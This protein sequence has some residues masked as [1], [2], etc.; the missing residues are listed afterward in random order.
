MTL[1]VQM[2]PSGHEFID[3]HMSDSLTPLSL[4][5]SRS[6]LCL[7]HSVTSLY[8]YSLTCSLLLDTTQNHAC[9]FDRGAKDRQEGHE[10]PSQEVNLCIQFLLHKI[11]HVSTPL[12][13]PSHVAFLCL[14]HCTLSSL[15]GPRSL[16]RNSLCKHTVCC[17]AVFIQG[18]LFMVQV[19]VLLEFLAVYSL[20]RATNHVLSHG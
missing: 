20:W 17:C 4:S 8:H 9:V 7:S 10:G 2:S 5:L 3:K 11:T 18:L 15:C 6:L 13:L 19:S 14:F 12:L 16:L 1:L